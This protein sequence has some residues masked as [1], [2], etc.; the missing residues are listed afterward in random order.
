MNACLPSGAF[1]CA[2]DAWLAGQCAARSAQELPYCLE[3]AQLAALSSTLRYASSHSAL[4]SRRLHG[5]DVCPTS[6][7]AISNLPF[8]TANDLHPWEELLCTPLDAVE[9][10]VT[11]H[12]SGTTGS[13]KRLAFTQRDLERTLAF[14]AVGM[15]CLTGPGR[16]LAVL[17]PGS[18]RP[19]G[20]ADLLQQ[21][22]AP[23]DVTVSYPSPELLTPGSE[24]L[25]AIWLR[26]TAPHALVAMPTQ[27]AHLRD[28]MPQGLPNL[29]GILSSA[30]WLD[31]SLATDLR[32][33]W[34]CEVLNHYGLTETGYGCAVECPAHDGFHLR[35]LDVYVEIVDVAHGHP[36]PLG[37]PGEVVVTTLH[38]E[39][40]PLLR[41]RTGDM[42]SLLPGPCACGSPLPRLGSILGR[43]VRDG[44]TGE[45]RL[46]HPTKGRER[47]CASL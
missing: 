23:S 11:L 31:T 8:T 29:T 3:A 17:L 20:V 4:Y 26:K 1:A 12:T 27:L 45:T 41:Y 13:P 19:N 5:Y 44:A 28:I 18:A 14:F 16:T 24:D 9:R 22:L 34:H 42:A 2:L 35:A 33:R 43:L 32:T 21:A 47:S 15:T 40:M 7:E 6:L 25:L 46:A 10:M 37:E 30:E 36:L 38:R 39:A